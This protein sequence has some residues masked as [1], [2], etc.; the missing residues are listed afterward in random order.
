[1]SIPIE[2]VAHV[3]K[4]AQSIMVLT[5]A[6]MSAESGVPTFRDAL[7]GLWAK[8]NPQELAT[9]EAFRA[10]PKLVWDWYSFRRGLVANAQPNPGHIAIAQLQQLKPNFSLITQNVDEL[11]EQAGS[12]HVVHLHGKI[13]ETKCFFDCQGSPTLVDIRTLDYSEEATP[14][15]CPHCGRWLR[16]NVVWFNERL[17]IAE[18][19][20]ANEKAQQCTV[21]LVIG[22][23]G[24]VA[25]ASQ[26]PYVA[27]QFAKATLIEVNPQASTLTSDVDFWLQAPSGEVLPQVLEA[28]RA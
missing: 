21:M 12:T 10:N 9:P 13:A 26:L 18:L 28:I 22:T 3:L 2:Q 25:P 14:P 1:M 20:F 4:H 5:G 11:H 24:M 7:T 27:K 15:A 8:Y 17:P 6:G 16:P 23:S 19:E